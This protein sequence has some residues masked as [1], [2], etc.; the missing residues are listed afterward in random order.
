MCEYLEYMWSSGMGR[1]Q[2]ND[3][4]AALLDAQPNLKGLEAPENLVNK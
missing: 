2:A 1:A 3:T 4:V